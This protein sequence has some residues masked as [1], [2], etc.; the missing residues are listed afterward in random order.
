MKFCFVC[1]K[2]T[3]KLIEGYCED[4]Y[5]KKFVLVNVP[6]ELTLKICSKCERINYRNVWRDM[7]IEDVLK[8][9][10]KILGKNVDL[11][12]S[13]DDGII[14]VCAKG[15]LKD[16]R[17]QKEECYDIRLKMNKVVCRDCSRKFGDYYESILQLRGNAEKM[18]DFIED[19]LTNDK[20]YKIENVR[21]GIDVYLSDSHFAETLSKL[22]KKNFKAKIKKSFRL[23]TRKQGKD[24]YRST[25]VV[26]CD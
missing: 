17:K 26:R 23:L 22:L 15:F 4:C 24:I 5:N 11:R 6:K 2:K 12:I 18:F 21:N 25:F 1:G 14:S 3:E 10:I 13:R 7:E 8:D 16:S 9:K 19:R 20:V